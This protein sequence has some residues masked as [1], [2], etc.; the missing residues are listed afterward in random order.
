[1][2]GISFLS[3]NLYKSGDLSLTTGTAHAQFPLS[4]TKN[5]SPAV[6]FRST[7]NSAVIEIDLLQTRDIDTVAIAGDPYSGLGLTAASFKLS[8]TTDFSLSTVNNLDVSGSE[9]IAFKQITTESKRYVEI[10]LT[11]TGSYVEV[12][13]IFVGQSLNIPQN[14]L[15]IGSFSYGRK[16]NSEVISNNYG[17]KFVNLLPKLKVLGGSI[18]HCTKDE[19]QDIDD[20]LIR[21]GISEPLWIIVDPNNN[22]LNEGQFK[23]TMY[24]YLTQISDWSASGGQLYTVNIKMEQAG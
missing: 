9:A 24:G 10:T 6:K 13:N 18:E 7:G 19:Q 11:G 22:G 4:N 2:P 1:M 12:G 5:D 14:S 3:D 15:S 8:T 21:H 23:L 16:D 20:M 17:Q